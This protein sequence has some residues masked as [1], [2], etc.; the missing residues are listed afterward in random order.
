M[1]TERTANLSIQ[2]NLGSA[3]HG[4]PYSRE[5]ANGFLF[6]WIGDSFEAD[7][8]LVPSGDRTADALYGRI[9][10]VWAGSSLLLDAVP[11]G[12]LIIHTLRVSGFSALGMGGWCLFSFYKI[13][14]DSWR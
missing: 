13:I 4:I 10:E 3:R 6:G 9:F 7:C 11:G 5:I 14:F 12:R 8:A 2:F 1:R